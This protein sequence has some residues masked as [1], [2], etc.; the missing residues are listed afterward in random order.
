VPEE[1]LVGRAMIV[2][3]S[4]KQNASLFKPWTWLDLNWDRFFHI[5]R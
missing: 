2:M 4:W 3:V 1:N 5:I